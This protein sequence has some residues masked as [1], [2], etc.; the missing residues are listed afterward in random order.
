MPRRNC[1]EIHPWKGFGHR[2]LLA[3]VVFKVGAEFVR[4]PWGPDMARMLEFCDLNKHG[5]M[6]DS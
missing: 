6:V 4:Y 1:G 2:H 5:K 3:V